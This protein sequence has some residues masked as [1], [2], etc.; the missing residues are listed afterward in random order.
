MKFQN[1]MQYRYTRVDSV[2]WTSIILGMLLG[3]IGRIVITK[4]LWVGVGLQIAEYILFIYGMWRPFS[5]SIWKRDRE[6]RRLLSVLR[7]IKSWFLLL[8]RRIKF[9]KTSVFKVCPHC[10]AQLKLPRK[11]GKHTVKCPKCYT[12]FDIKIK[13]GKK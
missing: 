1:F 6:N 3:L 8:G 4:S 7:P 2:T 5:K 11:R 10:K 13:F 9:M 12:R